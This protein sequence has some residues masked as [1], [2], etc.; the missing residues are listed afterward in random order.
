M[1]YLKPSFRLWYIF[2]FFIL[3]K[4]THISEVDFINYFWL[5]TFLFLFNFFFRFLRPKIKVTKQILYFLLCF[6]I[7]WSKLFFLLM[8]P[9]LLLF[10]YTQYCAYYAHNLSSVTH[11]LWI[12][13][14]CYE[15]KKECKEDFMIFRFLFSSYICCKKLIFIFGK[16]LSLLCFCVAYIKEKNIKAYFLGKQ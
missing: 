15:R 13:F 12:L 14:I 11:M 1:K 8:L 7:F 3:L 4:I 2:F 16:L 10:L 9:L 5:F 6:S